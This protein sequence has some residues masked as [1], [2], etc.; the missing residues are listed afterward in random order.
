MV[1][2]E[3]Q[4]VACAAPV[5]RVHE[6]RILRDGPLGSSTRY[7]IDNMQEGRVS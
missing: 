5:G 4:A 1:L 3:E 2:G 7:S 6:R